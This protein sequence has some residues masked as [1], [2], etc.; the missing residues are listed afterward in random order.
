MVW[1]QITQFEKIKTISQLK[2]TEGCLLSNRAENILLV[3]GFGNL[4][5]TDSSRCTE[6]H[7]FVDVNKDN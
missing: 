1:I 7:T 3:V 2:Q 5:F 6:H 4:T